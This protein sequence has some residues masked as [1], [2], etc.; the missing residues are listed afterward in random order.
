M[1]IYLVTKMELCYYECSIISVYI[2]I[3]HSIKL[4][5]YSE[6]SMLNPNYFITAGDFLDAHMDFSRY[7]K[8]EMLM[9]QKKLNN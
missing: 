5:F 9:E 4:S 1:I 8:G 2:G 6:K 7:T 3:F